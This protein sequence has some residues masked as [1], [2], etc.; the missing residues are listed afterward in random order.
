MR[1]SKALWLFS[2]IFAVVGLK[3][4]NYS[5]SGFVK[6][7]TSGESIKGAVVKNLSDGA[8]V[9]TNNYGFFSLTLPSGRQSVRISASEYE[10]VTLVRIVQSDEQI[11]IFLLP[12]A[13]EID[14][15]RIRA[16][17][18]DNVRAV[19]I[20]TQSITGKVIKK[21]PAFLGE[22]D[23]I[24][25]IQLLPGVTTVGEGATGFNV[26]G[27]GI[28]QNLVLM[29]DAP[30]FNSAHL[31]GFFSIFNPDAVK[32]VQLIKGGIPAK[33]GGRLSS[34]LDV[35]TKDGN[36]RDYQVNGGIG[37]IFSR[38]TFEGPVV[39][40]K[41]SFLVSGRRSYIDVLA[42]PLLNEDLEGSQ[43]YF[44]DF[45][46]KFNY[47]NGRDKF[48]I[49]SY[50]GDDLFFAANAFGVKW[51]NSTLS[52]RWNH[53]FNDKLF[54]NLTYYYS[55]YRYN[56]EFN[57]GDDLSFDW[58][59]YINNHSLKTDFTYYLNSKNEIGF[60]GSSTYYIFEPGTATAVNNLGENTFGVPNKYAME[61]ALY[62]SDD[63]TPN[64]RFTIRAGIRGSQFIYL[65]K[66]I[67]YT[68]SDPFTE[69]QRRFVDSVWQAGNNE[70]IQQYLN[71]EPRLGFKYQWNRNSSIKGGYNR[72]VQNLHLIS[73]TAA[74]VPFDV[75]SP[76]TNNIK[77]ELADQYTLG[78]FKNFSIGKQEF[79]SS[80]EVYYKDMLNQVD[81]V[82]GANLLLNELLEGELI[83]GIGRAYGL[84]LYV[85]K[86]TGDL[87]GWVSYTLSRSERKSPGISDNEWYPSR[88]DRL[89]NLYIVTQ[90]RLNE[91][92]DLAAN[93]VFSSGTPTTFYTGQ[94]NI[95][96]YTIPDAG[97]NDRNNV[98]NPIYHRLDLS[99]TY[100]KKKK[101]KWESNWVFSVYNAYNR[102]N[103]FSIY[104]EN[105]YQNTG[106]NRAIQF[107]VIGSIVPAISY[108]FKWN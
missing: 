95:Q 74:S 35:I 9:T 24:K 4:Q 7:S 18:N 92:W 90:Y 32:D 66:S 36:N 89:H 59:S 3:A 11:S 78:Y 70:V 68:F 40:N 41:A 28:D 77:P 93:F 10:V 57:I 43:F 104:F 82:D 79:E 107:S 20:S 33:Y 45:T 13:D 25:S 80:A 37:T 91:K 75:W 34:V 62:L 56:L 39:K 67:V 87:T 105:N 26:R 52:A 100:T 50:I 2:F 15:V 73:N 22:A 106:I 49:S 58:Q 12:T 64:N 96:G 85:K 86:A 21:I 53:I 71:L 27:G 98:R 94:Y 48:F 31:F 65:G 69:G 44:Y 46:A 29:D 102:R 19:D 108:N 54:S 17:R 14:E 8:S 1:W 47:D 84:E 63:W 16:K 60:G 61:N 99:A 42:K 101:G 81:Y 5:F 30:V 97:S 38:L 103:P 6:D 76:S 88:F 51:G 72:M 55:R 23:V 83:N